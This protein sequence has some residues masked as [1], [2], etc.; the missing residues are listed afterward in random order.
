MLSLNHSKEWDPKYDLCHSSADKFLHFPD[1]CGLI[2][3][4]MVLNTIFNTMWVCEHKL[5]AVDPPFDDYSPNFGL[6]CQQRK[7]ATLLSRIFW[8]NF[9]TIGGSGHAA[10]YF[11][12]VDITFTDA[13]LNCL[14]KMI[15]QC[16][17]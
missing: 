6:K 17:N 3:Y 1:Q 14:Y 9:C 8:L 16:H 13:P 7:M 10:I 5:R 2:S 4:W 11:M 12:L 15:C